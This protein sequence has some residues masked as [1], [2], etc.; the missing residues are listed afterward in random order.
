MMSRRI[1]YVVDLDERGEFAATVYDGKT[2]LAEF[3]TEDIQFLIEHY[4][5]V[6]GRDGVAVFEYLLAVGVL[7]QNDTLVTEG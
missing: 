7:D 6:S 1:A 3:K 4:G 2:I 5:A